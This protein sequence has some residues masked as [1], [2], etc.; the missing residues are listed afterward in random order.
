MSTNREKMYKHTVE[1]NE[2]GLF[3][4]KWVELELTLAIIR[5]TQKDKYY[6]FSHV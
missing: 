4:E 5:K 3:T 2:L 1:K 6:V